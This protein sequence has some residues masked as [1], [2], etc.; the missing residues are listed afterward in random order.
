ML[1]IGGTI[2][3]ITCGKFG[4]GAVTAG[5]AQMLNGNQKV[6]GYLN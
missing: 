1:T 3:N 6:N 2:S 4:N 5:F